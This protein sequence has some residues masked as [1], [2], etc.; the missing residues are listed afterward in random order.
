VSGYGFIVSNRKYLFHIR[1]HRLRVVAG[2]LSEYSAKIKAAKQMLDA[3]IPT[4]R[5]DREAV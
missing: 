4:K 2:I 1:G 3:L 5:R